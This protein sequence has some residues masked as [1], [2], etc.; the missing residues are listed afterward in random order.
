MIKQLPKNLLRQWQL[1]RQRLPYKRHLKFL[2]SSNY[3]PTIKK[4][5]LTDRELSDGGIKGSGHVPKGSVAVYVGPELRRFVIPLRFLAMPE[6]RDLMDEAAEEFGF[7]KEG[8]LQIPCDVQYFEY[9]L[10][11]CATQLNV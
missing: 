2:S 4:S 10:L 6:F 9:V 8:G 1:Q 3:D 11:R 5:L 7:Q